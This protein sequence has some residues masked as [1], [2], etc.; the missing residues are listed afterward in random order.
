M[1]ILN[2]YNGNPF[3]LFGF[4]EI[5]NDHGRYKELYK[6]ITR[7]NSVCSCTVVIHSNGIYSVLTAFAGQEFSKLT[8]EYKYFQYKNVDDFDEM[9]D[10]AR[11]VMLEQSA[12]LIDITK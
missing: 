10:T 5:A 8:S 4:D 9:F 7:N 6:K 1:S 11:K 3:K 2:K 12:N